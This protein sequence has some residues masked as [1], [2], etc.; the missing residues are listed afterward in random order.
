MRKPRA[1]TE[2][3]NDLDREVVG[4]FEVLRDPDG[5]ARLQAALEFTPFARDEFTGAYEA[6]DDAIE[7]CRRLLIRSSM[8]FGGGGFNSANKTGFRD[9]KRSGAT[10]S[11]TWA[12]YPDQIS[13]FTDRLRGIV[14]ENR[15]AIDVMR[16][17]DGPDT[18]HYV[19]PPYLPDTRSGGARYHIYRHEMT[20]EDHAELVAFLPTLAGMVVL[21]GYPS[22][23]YDDALSG[24]RRVERVALAEGA[25][26]RTEVLWINTAAAAGMNQ[27]QPDLLTE[28]RTTGPQGEHGGNDATDC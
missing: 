11:R 28:M 3:Y 13:A 24:W 2:I 8:G 7:R 17:H 16:R 10:P 23:M 14:I 19:D 5:A 22:D 12:T 6:T 26:E 25:R 27:V 20:A 15:P 9:S 1:Y 4:L 21:S 18:L